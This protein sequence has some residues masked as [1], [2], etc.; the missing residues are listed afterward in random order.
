MISHLLSS[1]EASTNS[2]S[3]QSEKDFQHLQNKL[4]PLNKLDNTPSINFTQVSLAFRHSVQM[5]TYQVL[6]LKL[7]KLAQQ[8]EPQYHFIELAFT[9]Q[10]ARSL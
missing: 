1:R 5:P 3:K 4:I 7:H 6:S 8:T 2:L 10:P 9:F